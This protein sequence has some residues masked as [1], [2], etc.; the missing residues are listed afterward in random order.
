LSRTDYNGVVQ[1]INEHLVFREGGYS[2]SVTQRL[3]LGAA[4]EKKAWK[5]TAA[6][7]RAK[8]QEKP[9]KNAQSPS[10]PLHAVLGE[11]FTRNHAFYCGR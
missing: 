3:A 7:R 2:H 9:Q 4:G 1:R 6:K 5:R 10:R 11:V 8:A